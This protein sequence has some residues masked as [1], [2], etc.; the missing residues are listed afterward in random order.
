M[1]CGFLPLPFR[2]AGVG[3]MEG[4]R[5]VD[6]VRLCKTG[7]EELV[8]SSAIPELSF[9][10]ASRDACAKKLRSCACAKNKEATG[11]STFLNTQRKNDPTFHGKRRPSEPHFAHTLPQEKTSQAEIPG[12][13]K[14]E[15]RA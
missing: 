8:E 12:T 5:C 11:R 7:D 6:V 15:K 4:R 14:F 9:V 2:L 3:D 13:T 1:G 10:C